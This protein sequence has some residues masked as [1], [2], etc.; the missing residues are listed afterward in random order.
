MQKL[1]SAA[2]IGNTGPSRQQKD[3]HRKRKHVLA[4]E[5]SPV[6][7]F[8]ED[9][10]QTA[11][12]RGASRPPQSDSLIEQRFYERDKGHYCESGGSMKPPTSS[13][14]NH[15]FE[16]RPRYK[17]RSDRYD[18]VRNDK[19]DREKSK[20]G[21]SR[22][23][24]G[25]TKKDRKTRNQMTSAKEATDNFNSQSIL[26]NRVTVPPSFSPGLFGNGRRSG[27]LVT[28]LA[29]HE[30]SFLKQPRQEARKS[31]SRNRESQRKRDDRQFEEISAFF[32]PKGPPERHDAQDRR[33]SVAS[34]LSSYD[35]RTGGNST[36]TSGHQILKDWPNLVPTR[37][38]YGPKLVGQQPA[39]YDYNHQTH[40]W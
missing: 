13:P 2:S 18:V 40:R 4:A 28:D 29:F 37:D 38:Q 31:L 34:A 21:K 11:R 5:A 22:K 23:P 17:T 14:T 35:G 10:G 36:H 27:R 25:D 39:F 7:A 9:F 30:M 32:A 3:Q 8:D 24:R 20:E 1:P 19:S 15:Q 16:K 26:S 12:H 6:V 33:Q